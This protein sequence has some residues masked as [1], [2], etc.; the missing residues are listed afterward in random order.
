M[1]HPV[2][3]GPADDAAR[4]QIQD[5]GQIQPTFA[6]PY[7]AD[8]FGPFLVGAI[9]QEVLIQHIGRDV[10]RVVAVLRA[11]TESGV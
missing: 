8:V 7:V 6:G 5:D 10:E 1:F 2:T 9:S 3:D 4:V 11:M